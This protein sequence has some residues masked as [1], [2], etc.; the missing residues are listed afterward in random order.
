LIGF[1]RGKGGRVGVDRTGRLDHMDVRLIKGD[2][3]V[4]MMA[5]LMNK[6]PGGK[7]EFTV[8]PQVSDKPCKSLDGPGLGT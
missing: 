1:S 7:G 6:K 5:K 2:E 4:K 3:M 8:Q